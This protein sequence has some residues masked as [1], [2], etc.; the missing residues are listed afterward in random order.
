MLYIEQGGSSSRP[1]STQG[2]GE[3]PSS[4]AFAS[5]QGFVS[6]S[7]PAKTMRRWPSPYRGDHPSPP[8]PPSPGGGGL[9]LGA[10]R[11]L[12]AGAGAGEGAGAGSARGRRGDLRG[13]RRARARGLGRD[14]RGERSPGSAPAWV[15]VGTFGGSDEVSSSLSSC[16]SVPAVALPKANAAPKATTRAAS[17]AMARGR[18]SIYGLAVL[19]PARG[20][21]RSA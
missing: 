6:R 17:A 7:S 1:A 13:G 4:R 10:G 9:G 19:S 2:R 3:S 16:P 8:P 21:A 20:S 15:S 14:L 11:G 5:P 12:G 18:V